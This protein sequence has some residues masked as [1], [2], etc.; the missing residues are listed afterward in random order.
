MKSPS[1]APA[2]NSGRGTTTLNEPFSRYMDTGLLLSST[3]STGDHRSWFIFGARTETPP[4]TGSATYLGR[5]L[6]RAYRADDPNRSHRQRITGA[7]RLVANFDLNQLQGTIDAIRK[8]NYTGTL[9]DWPTSSFEIT[10]GRIQGGQ[11]TATLI[12]NDSDPDASFD[13]SLK[14]F[15]GSI[16]G[17]FYG[18]NADEIGGVVSAERDAV[19]QE[20][21][22][23]LYG[24]VNGKN[25][26]PYSEAA[27]A[28][29]LYPLSGR[30]FGS[31]TK[32]LIVMAHGRASGGGP[33]DY[34]Y[35][36]A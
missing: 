25:I 26:E 32:V 17:E 34:M 18:P 2:F 9:T 27:A 15:T 20:Y 16:L 23:V 35:Q 33:S 36:Y 24:Y 22:R 3:G 31:G 13:E 6:A 21:G 12:G 8:R 4:T 7:M 10:D 19:G 30:V 5:F 1:P 29:G 11:F 14:G 28:T